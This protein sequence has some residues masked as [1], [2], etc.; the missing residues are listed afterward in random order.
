MSEEYV[1]ERSIPGVLLAVIVV[2]LLAGLGSLVWCYGLQNHLGV[3]Q[4]R[5]AAAD[6]KNADL[7]QKL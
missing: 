2:A 3:A 6:Q 5:L 7:A 1:E 4:Q